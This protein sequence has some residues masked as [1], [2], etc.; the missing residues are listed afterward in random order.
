MAEPER[1][2]V[3]QNNQAIALKDTTGSVFNA[4]GASHSPGLVPDP[5][6]AAGTT[7]FLREDATFQSI[8]T[9]SVFPTPTRAGD[10]VYWNGSSWVTLA[11]NNTGTQIL[12][13]TSAGVP[14]WITPTGPTY[15]SF[16]TGSGNYTPTSA[17]VV[18]IKVRMCGGGGGG[19]AV[20][21][22]VGSNGTDTSF[23]TWTAIHGG[24]GGISGT[25][26][27][28]SGGTGGVNGTGTLIVRFNGGTGAASG[29]TSS[30]AAPGGTGGSNPFAG[31]GNGAIGNHAGANAAPNTGAGGQGAGAAASSNYGGGGGAGEYVEFLVSS[32]GTIA[33]VV[34]GGGNGGAAGTNAGGNGAAGII[35]V[36]EFYI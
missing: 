31:A 3:Y 22:N 34:G 20:T 18:R 6:S 14:S 2:V 12:Q 30:V 21:T 33:Y 5:G 29:P 19:G 36:E 24:G 13:E 4:S 1:F 35:L 25:G 10:I 23:G 16:T 15:Q 28:G 17:S 32:P 11:G 26:T 27:G 9:S 7:K 8:T